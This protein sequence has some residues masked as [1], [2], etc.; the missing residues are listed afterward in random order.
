LQDLV[1][2]VNWLGRSN[3]EDYPNLISRNAEQIRYFIGQLNAAD[4]ARDN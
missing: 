2:I 4:E 1:D 3:I